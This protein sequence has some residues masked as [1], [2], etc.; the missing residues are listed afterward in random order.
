L[1]NRSGRQVLSVSQIAPGIQRDL[2]GEAILML[3]GMNQDEWNSGLF[4]RRRTMIAIE[5]GTISETPGNLAGEF[6][7]QWCN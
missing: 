7:Q 5:P 6:H 3:R 1:E 4:T 2:R